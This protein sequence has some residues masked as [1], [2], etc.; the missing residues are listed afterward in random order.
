MKI[1][2][3]SN[4]LNLVE[5]GNYISKK[6]CS[7]L[8]NENSFTTPILSIENI[9]SNSYN[10]V[11]LGDYKNQESISGLSN[12]ISVGQKGLIKHYDSDPLFKNN[13]NTK[14]KVI[15]T[16]SDGMYTTVNV[17]T[18]SI[19]LNSFIND[20]VW[21]ISVKKSDLNK[22]QIP[23]NI[24]TTDLKNDLINIGKKTVNVYWDKPETYNS[25]GLCYRKQTD[26]S[27]TN[28]TY[29]YDITE[30]VYSLSNLD[31]DSPYSV[32]VMIFYKDNEF[33]VFSDEIMFTT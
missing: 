27:N 25:F 13:T 28:W 6:E 29:V 30:N 20:A 33:S 7:S 5:D 19:I 32:C 23:T 31:A 17:I 18:E 10:I 9:F 24:Y 2:E 14:F 1:N 12:R 15:K 16:T 26:L 3:S 4:D 21:N 8:E 22:N 11:V